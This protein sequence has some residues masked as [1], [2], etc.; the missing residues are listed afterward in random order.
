MSEGHLVDKQVDVFAKLGNTVVVAE[1][2]SSARRGQRSLQ[3]DV[4]E[5][6]SLQRA[7]S[8]SLRKHY[9]AQAKLKII[10]LMVTSNVNWSEANKSRA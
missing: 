1:W 9:S 8:N 6:A 3:K 7:I 5:L 4:G 2:I 10:W